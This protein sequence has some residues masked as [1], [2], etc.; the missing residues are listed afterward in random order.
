MWTWTQQ[1]Y[2]MIESEKKQKQKQMTKWP[3]YVDDSYYAGNQMKLKLRNNAKTWLGEPRGSKQNNFF[4]SAFSIDHIAEWLFLCMKQLKARETYYLL[5]SKCVLFYQKI[6]DSS[7]HQL[8]PRVL[9]NCRRMLTWRHMIL[10]KLFFRL[11]M[12]CLRILTF[13]TKKW[14]ITWI[15]LRVHYTHDSSNCTIRDP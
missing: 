14:S 12:N 10:I 15:T 8:S 1:Q 11:I 13:H 3:A 2:Q 9:E 5:R 6:W 7:I 4:C